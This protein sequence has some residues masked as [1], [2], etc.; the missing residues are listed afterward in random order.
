MKRIAV[1]TSGGDA[2][3]M[4]AAIRSIVRTAIFH[5]LEVIGVKRGYCGLI[6]GDYAKMNLGSVSDVIHRGGTILGTARCRDFFNEEGRQTAL[7]KM[8]Q[9]RIEGLIA[10]G[11]DGTFN[12]AAKLDNSGMPVIAVP[13]TIDNDIA[14]TDRTIGFDTVINTVLDAINKIRDTAT[15][16]E[17]IF[18][19]E[20]MGRN[21]GAIA[22]AAGLAG[23]A[24]SILIPEIPLN[25]EQVVSNIKRGIA[26]GKR[27]SIIVLAEGLAN[28][29][30]ITKQIEAMAQLE[31]RLTILGYLQRGGTPTAQDRILA[32]RMGAEAVYM[33]L[34]GERNKMVA[35]KGDMITSVDIECA[36][37][38]KKELNFQDYKLAGIL[39]R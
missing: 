39:S 24:E 12:G 26:R 36:L 23:G 30:D 29:L 38:Q 25:L 17:R 13:G 8:R 3:G 5:R 1:L 31:T 37:L 15:S 27:H 35:S 18:V 28:S 33:L 14:C 11:G 16:H 2:P 9:A 22:L 20:V 32:S 34:R 10:I 19:I 7:L 21:S 6:E 4:N